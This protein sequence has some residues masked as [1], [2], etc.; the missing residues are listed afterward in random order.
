MN[1]KIRLRA[2]LNNFERSWECYAS[3]LGERERE[4]FKFYQWVVS[5]YT[6]E[7][8]R[9]NRLTRSSKGAR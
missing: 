8:K 4:G 9:A 3:P 7:I 6:G 2:L 5:T 1:P